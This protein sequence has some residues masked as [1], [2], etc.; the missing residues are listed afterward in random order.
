MQI[1]D[2]MFLMFQIISSF[3]L[4]AGTFAAIYFT[5]KLI[6]GGFRS[7]EKRLR[8]KGGIMTM[9]FRIMSILFIYQTLFF[10]FL[11]YKYKF[12]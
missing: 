1:L 11:F 2:Y 3:I 9:L 12:S 7:L 4:F 5:F 6:R 10:L 8:I